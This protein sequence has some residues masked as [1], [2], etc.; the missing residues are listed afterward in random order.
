[1]KQLLQYLD[2]NHLFHF[3]LTVT[4][5]FMYYGTVVNNQPSIVF[6][7]MSFV[8]VAFWFASAGITRVSNQIQDTNTKVEALKT[9]VDTQELK[10][11]SK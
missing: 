5:L 6:E 8:V 7:N 10:Q 1:M 11:Q 9:K 2:Q 3:F 4:I